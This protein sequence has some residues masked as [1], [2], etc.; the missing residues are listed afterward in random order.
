MDVSSLACAV[1]RGPMSCPF[2]DKAYKGV[3]GIKRHLAHGCEAAIDAGLDRT[4]VPDGF[5]VAK[6][7]ADGSTD[8]KRKANE[9]GVEPEPG[10]GGLR[11]R[12]VAPRRAPAPLVLAK[13]ELATDGDDGEER[14]ER[15]TSAADAGDAG[16]LRMLREKLAAQERRSAELREIN[17][18]ALE[19]TKRVMAMS[20]EGDGGATR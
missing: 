2:C 19:L 6:V 7:A 16:E 11:T 9:A 3:R 17:L 1:R 12:R 18:L 13:P 20:A 10:A 15:V 14:D 4:A 5:V 8:L